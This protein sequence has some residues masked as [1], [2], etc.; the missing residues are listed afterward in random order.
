MT[1]TT[2]P[3]DALSVGK[4]TKKSLWTGVRT[5]QEDHETR[6]NTL[7]AGTGKIQAFNF[8]VCGYI[9]HYTISELVAVG[10][11]LVPAA[12]SL[13]ECSITILDS[14]NGFDAAGDA[15]V[16]GD[17]G[18]LEIDLLKST[19]SGV[20][21]NSILTTKPAIIDGESGKGVSSNDSP[22]TA[23][24]FSDTSLD[25]DDILQINI[26]GLKDTQGTLLISVYGSLD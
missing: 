21:F 13:L 19:D 12:Y 25:Q 6:L 3:L 24:V 16:T 2:V 22:N 26:T 14:A 20:T 23:A 10:N 17:D 1:Y 18:T 5:N 9:G 15:V 4:P 11:H 8:Q 7:E